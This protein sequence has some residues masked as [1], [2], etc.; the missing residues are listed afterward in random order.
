[1][2]RVKRVAHLLENL[3]QGGIA[4][5]VLPL[6]GQMCDEGVETHVLL[7]KPRIEFDVDS[8]IRLRRL[9]IHGLS[10]SSRSSR[11]LRRCG[12]TVC[13]ERRYWHLASTWFVSQLRR[14]IAADNFDCIFFHGLPVCWPFHRWRDGRAWFVLHNKKSAQLTSGP[15]ANVKYLGLYRET[16]AAKRLIAVSEEVR[17]DAIVNFGVTPKAIVTVNNPFDFAAIRQLSL[18][19]VALTPD[20]ARAGFILAVGRL[21]TQKRF[22]I[23][24][25]AYHQAALNEHLVIIGNG[26][27]QEEL[28]AL[29]DHLGI[30][31]KV[32][33]LGFVKNPYA[34]MRHARGLVFSSDYEG[35]GNV[36]VEALVCGTRVVSTR[37]GAAADILRGPLAAGLVQCGDIAGLAT[38]LRALINQSIPP[39]DIDELRRFEQSAVASEY[40]RLAEQQ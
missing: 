17:Q 30:A 13:G 31:G 2:S 28:V 26:V 3:N 27:L 39:A 8:R 4:R 38:K 22:D 21:V 11:W 10:A 18:E 5:V 32:H 24:L 12:R 6:A 25:R 29:A 37:V 20:L 7:L 33:F 23:L 35:F 40:L 36:L 34:Y 15:K 14:Q 16:L 9:A 1:M 19:P